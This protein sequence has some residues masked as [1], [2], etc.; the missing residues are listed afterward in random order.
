MPRIP[1]AFLGCIVYIYPS[2][3]SATSGEKFGGTGFLISAPVAGSTLVRQHVVT[4]SHV[5]VNGR[6]IR[7]E[8][9]GGTEI[10][11]FNISDWTHHHHGDDVAVVALGEPGVTFPFQSLSSEL[12]ITRSTVTELGIGPGD[13]TFTISRFIAHDGTQRNS[14]LVRFGNIAMMPGEPIYQTDRSFQQESF[15]IEARSLSGFSGSPVFLYIPPFSHRY[16]TGRFEQ[17]DL[18]LNPSTTLMLLGIDWGHM[19]LADEDQNFVNSGVMAAVPSW[20]I[21]ELLSA[22]TE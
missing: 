20:K 17:D 13:D 14:P 11:E 3:S 16:K 12:L 5:A 22:A 18:G 1:D 2:R 9:V 10:F 15:L 4:N 8:G 7:I 6:A 21:Q 19:L